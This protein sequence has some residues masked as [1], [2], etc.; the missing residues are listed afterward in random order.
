VD[1]VKKHLE[2]YCNIILIIFN[3]YIL[4]V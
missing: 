1:L 3:P 2:L 4:R